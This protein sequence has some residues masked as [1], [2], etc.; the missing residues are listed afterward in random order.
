MWSWFQRIAL[1]VSHCAISEAE[2]SG[3]V[4]IRELGE[5]NDNSQVLCL[6][7]L[8]L[9]RFL[10]PFSVL[11]FVAKLIFILEFSGQ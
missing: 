3:S 9:A 4:F 10:A 2:V 7:E 6:H 1:I 8:P 11:R 5:Q